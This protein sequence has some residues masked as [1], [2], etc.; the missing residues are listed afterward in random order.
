MIKLLY[1]KSNIACEILS[2]SGF[3]VW[4]IVHK[5]QLSLLRQITTTYNSNLEEIAETDNNQKRTNPSE[6]V[7]VFQS[8]LKDYGELYAHLT[9]RKCLQV[10][11]DN[12]LSLNLNNAVII[13]FHKELNNDLLSSLY[14]NQNTYS[15]GLI[16]GHNIEEIHDQI[17]M[18]SASLM[19]SSTHVY[20]N[21][22]RLDLFPG[23]KINKT[24]K[25][26]NNHIILAGNLPTQEIQRRLSNFN[27]DLTQIFTHSDG[28]DMS[29]GKAVMCPL[30]ND[31]PNIDNKN[32]SCVITSHCH[33]IKKD[34]RV[35]L[36]SDL[37]ISPDMI[38]SK[39]FISHICWGILFSKNVIDPRWGIV[40]SFLKNPNI[41][42]CITT[43]KAVRSNFDTLEDLIHD[44]LK[45]HSVGQA[46][47][48]FNNSSNSRK[49]DIN[50][51]ILGDP[52]FKLN[53]VENLD[54]KLLKIRIQTKNKTSFIEE[55]KALTF[56]RLFFNKKKDKLTENKKILEAQKI[57][58]LID[59][60]E[61]YYFCGKSNEIE[62]DFI[63][64]VLH[65]FAYGTY[66][67]LEIW[68][69]FFEETE[70][71]SSNKKCILC[72]TQTTNHIFVPRHRE[73]LSNRSI[74]NCPNCGIIKDIDT[75]SG[76]DLDFRIVDSNKVEI[77]GI[78]L[79]AKATLTFHYRGKTL[80]KNYLHI[81]TNWNV[82]NKIID[83]PNKLIRKEPLFLTLYVI[84]NLK[85]H[86]I[87]YQI[88]GE[89]FN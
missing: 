42:V 86:L 19:L 24:L 77:I 36:N 62:E 54:E 28:V 63:N 15:P 52:K 50:L 26:S 12:L 72:K 73:T 13:C 79:N 48:N 64:L 32:P 18:N 56:F 9:N 38:K 53:P 68:G 21:I 80:K 65:F 1:K 29:L 85:L 67:P 16:I 4:P 61:S 11:L 84:Y 81:K 87:T 45:G 5:S 41:G 20:N 55:L 60:I 8:D 44:M 69:D 43:W 59:T 25:P 57:L 34:I 51:C 22:N 82:D 76:L 70:F 88:R 46:I 17:L 89:F 7:Y 14:Q 31:F 75:S 10:E 33:R 3:P 39:I 71:I 6:F 23:L 27:N 2:F 49:H 37:L 30:I 35:A 74:T 83:I 40:R 47:S 78:P 66:I 58:D